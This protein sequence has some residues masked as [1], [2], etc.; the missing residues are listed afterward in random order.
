MSV[1][2]HKELALPVARLVVLPTTRYRRSLRYT[3]SYYNAFVV[4]LQCLL[5]CEELTCLQTL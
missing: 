1:Y 4:K 5:L 3:Q 2:H